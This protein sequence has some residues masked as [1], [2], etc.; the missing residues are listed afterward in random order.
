M[1]PPLPPHDHFDTWLT[2]L[3]SGH[4][5][6]AL[7]HV[8]ACLLRMRLYCHP[9]PR[10]PPVETRPRLRGSPSG[11]GA[12]L[13]VTT[14]RC[15]ADWQ[16]KPRSHSETMNQLRRLSRRPRSSTPSPCPHGKARPR[17]KSWKTT[18]AKQWKP[19]ASWCASRRA[20][21]LSSLLPPPP[22]VT[23]THPPSV[24]LT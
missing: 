12:R 16:A 6:L 15:S 3:L 5:C 7:R 18:L 19:I 4:R 13:K 9:P 1:R 10:C 17:R 11:G 24:R 22:S 2:G 14:L 23:A 21:V 20:R 8:H